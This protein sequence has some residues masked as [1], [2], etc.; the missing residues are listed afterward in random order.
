MII[1]RIYEHAKLHIDGDFPW[2]YA[3]RW[4]LEAQ[5]LIATMC[6]TGSIPDTLTIEVKEPNKWHDLPKNTVKI[7]KVYI[8][9]QET[10]NFKEDTL[11]VFLPEKGKYLIEYKRLP[12][13]IGKESDEPELHELYHYPMSYWLASREQYRFNPD[14]QDGARLESTF[15]QEIALV[16]NMLKNRKRVRKIKV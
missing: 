11:R 10:N 1:K 13:I 7:N 6:E 9:N 4:L 15:Y 5:N 16:D 3:H 12:K 2:P 8:D 14:S